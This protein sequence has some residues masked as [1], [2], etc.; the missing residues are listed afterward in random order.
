MLPR[1]A[2]L[3]L[4]PLF[5]AVAFAVAY[6]VFYRGGYEPA[7]TPEPPLLEI[8][9]AWLS[10]RIPA[11]PSLGQLREGLLVVDAQ[12]ANSFTEAEL[13]SFAA[14]VAARGF[15][16]EF[17]GDFTPLADPSLAQPRFL[18]LADRLRRADAF[19]VILPQVPFTGAEAALVESFVQ[20]GGKLLLV[21]DPGRPQSISGLAERFGVDFQPDYL[22]NTVENDINYRRI[23]IRDFQPDQLTAGL[24]TVTLEYTGSVQSPGGGLLF[25]GAGTKSSVQ[26]G[27]KTYSPVAWGDTRNVLAMA[28]FTFMVPI[29]DSL[30]DNG[31]LVSN[32]ADYVTDSQRKF[33][34]SDFPNFY[35][36]GADGG[37]D[38]LLGRPELLANGQQMKSGLA[39]YRLSS[40]VAPT[41]DLSRDTVFL[42]LFG[43]AP[44]VSH[45]LEVSGIRVDDTLGTPFVSDLE[46]DGAAV[47]VLDQSQGR[48]MM[49]VLADTPDTLSVAV[50][51]LLSGEYRGDLLNDYIGVHKL[52]AEGRNFQAASQ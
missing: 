14:R 21:S 2:L 13:A 30:L 26:E 19:A 32:I 24:E 33:L 38:I 22:Y 15:D 12:H 37:V 52:P 50:G 7:T 47:V 18:E 3:A 16:V 8:S 35:R 39:P 48:D 23:F 10:P 25:T 46:L 1:L 27:V 28:D 5:A 34:L 44:Q 20:K 41:E 36:R 17:L 42:G 29:N 31:R 49:V 51:R 4:L 9:N 6:F 11:E 43:D 45:Y 40:R